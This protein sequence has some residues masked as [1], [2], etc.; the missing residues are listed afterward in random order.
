MVDFEKLGVFYL[1]TSTQ[2]QT[3][4]QQHSQDLVL[5][6]S[7]DLATHG[8]IVGMTGSGKTGLGISLLE[9]A[10]LD[11]IPVLA[12]DPKG[13]LG[14]LM[15]AFPSLEPAAFEPWINEADARAQGLSVH[16]MAKKLSKDAREGLAQSGQQPERIQR[17]KDAAEFVLYTPGSDAGVNVSMLGSLD[18]PSAEPSRHDAAFLAE[19]A[20]N[21]VSALLQLMGLNVDAQSKQHV[22]LCHALLW[23]WEHQRPVTLGAMLGWLDAPPF[24]QIGLMDIEGFFSSKER[25][26]LAVKLNALL[27]APTS[28]IWLSGQPIDIADML[29]GSNGKPKVSI[30]SIAH[31]DDDIRMFFVT[32][33]MNHI[34]SWMRTQSGTSSLRTL[35]YMDECAGYFPPVAMPSSKPP[36]MTLMKQG[37]AYGA[38][39][40]MA[41]QNPVDIDYKGL[42]NAGT[43]FIGRLQTEQ[44]KARIIEG[45]KHADK[46][47]GLSEAYITSTLGS[48]PKRT[49]WM[50]NVHEDEP[51][52]FRTRWCLS[53]LKGPMSLT[54]IKRLEQK[55]AAQSEKSVAHVGVPTGG[56]RPVLD[57]EQFFVTSSKSNDELFMVPTIGGMAEI[58]Y[59]HAGVDVT[60]KVILV[61][62]PLGDAVA[63]DWSLGHLLSISPE[64][65]T[66]RAPS[67]TVSY[68]DISARFVQSKNH[69]AWQKSWM[70]YLQDHEVLSLYQDPETQEVSQPG[71]NL[72]AFVARIGMGQ[73]EQR[74]AALDEVRKKYADKIARLEERLRKAEST[75]SAQAA[76][77]RDQTLGTAL[78]A[79]IGIL[80]ALMGRRRS[81][82]TSAG[83]V[84]RGASRVFKEQHDVGRADENITVIRAQIQSMQGE[85]SQ[86]LEKVGLKPKD[87]R[88]IQVKPNASDIHVD[89]F[90]LIWLPHKKT[91]EGALEAAF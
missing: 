20:Q 82:I 58:R 54:D 18:L 88:S 33:L 89:C 67:T 25:K 1:G 46:V 64:A 59:G 19:H 60:R 85:M 87:V 49:F 71:E 29:Y 35:V 26:A 9:E 73:R 13:D 36:M 66:T 40:V 81:S 57:V 11:G 44:D 69:A 61:V 39:L 43:W 34:V 6:D 37:R 62:E 55:S 70:R 83:A 78:S 52:V 68:G 56:Q 72:A 84:A 10:A 50:H 45:L 15:L 53:Y 28:K 91:S 4:S 63:L 51:T 21:T 32:L 5:Y 23:A 31:L 27:A 77:V 86:A 8:F 14:N 3:Q 24:E 74:D 76:Q 79:G 38:G 17:L 80:N 30:F 47:K 7:K 90:G 41:T 12:I 22:F 16:E 2:T 42:A 48:L 65:I 75:K